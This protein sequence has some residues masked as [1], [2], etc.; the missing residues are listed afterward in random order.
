MPALQRRLPVAFG[1]RA[2]PLYGPGDITCL[3]LGLTQ[4]VVTWSDAELFEIV[5]HGVRFTRMPAWPA[6]ESDDEIW[7]MV[8]FLRKY[9]GLDQS[10]YQ[11]LA[12][13]SATQSRCEG[14]HATERLDVTGLIPRLAGQ[15][16]TYLHDSLEACESGKRPS[17]G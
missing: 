3:G 11:R 14:C 12:G 9:P 7:A 1:P 5:K 2:R 6:Q 4:V 17:G 15:S 8:A 16:A 10:T 13:I